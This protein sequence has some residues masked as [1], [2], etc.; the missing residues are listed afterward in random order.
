MVKK[1][2]NITMFIILLNSLKVAEIQI[3]SSKYGEKEKEK[4][5][6]R[7]KENNG[8]WRKLEKHIFVKPQ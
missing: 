8:K 4:K 7:E 1:Q 6:E 2:N 5:L 3:Y